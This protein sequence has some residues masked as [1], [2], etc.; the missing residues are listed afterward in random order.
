MTFFEF[1]KT[2]AIRVQEDAIFTDEELDQVPN[3]VD[4]E[5]CLKMNA[6]RREAIIKLRNASTE[7]EIINFGIYD[8]GDQMWMNQLIQAYQAWRS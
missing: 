2:R 1:I 7:G 6:W 5:E 8:C 4:R 3:D